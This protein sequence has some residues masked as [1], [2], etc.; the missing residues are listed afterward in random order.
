MSKSN[1]KSNG[2][3]NSFLISKNKTSRFSAAS[4]ASLTSDILRVS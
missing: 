4:R 3:S 2:N 1:V